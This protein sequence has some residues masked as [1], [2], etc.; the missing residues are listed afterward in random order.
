MVSV[1][2]PEREVNT[3]SPLFDVEKIRADFPILKQNVYGKPLVYLDNGATTQKPQQVIDRITDFYTSEYGTVRRGVYKLSEGST[4][5][6]ADTREKAKAFLNASKT[7][8]IVFTKGS[9]DAI[10]LVAHSF[11]WTY[12]KTGD[13]ILISSIEHHANI[14]PWQLIAERSGAVIKVIPCNDAGELLLDEYEELLSEKTKIVAINHVA[15]SLG[16]INPVKQMATMAHHVGAAILVDGAQGAPHLPVDVQDLDCDFYC[17]SGHKLYG[18]T[19]VGV[20][21]MKMKYAE[22]MVPYQSGGDM[23]DTVTFEK[24]T[25]TAPPYKFEA[26]TPAI[27]QVIGLGAAIDYVNAIGMAA[28]EA[29][30]EALTQYATEQLNQIDGLSILGTAK[31]KTSLISFVHDKAHSLDIGTL[32]DH[33]GVAIRTGHHCAQPVMQRFG[34]TATAR[35]SFGIYNTKAEVDTLVQALNKVIQLVS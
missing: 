13:E 19:G 27:A 16:T 23:I 9:T 22:A 7:E 30:E 14:V 26:G 29:H 17:F 5:Q 18:P 1:E 3:T 31:A 20:L 21:Y 8:E 25:F 4:Q 35:V 11:G 33:E 10:N 15:N 12:L 2:L 6:F 24:T 32:I 34:V 28:I